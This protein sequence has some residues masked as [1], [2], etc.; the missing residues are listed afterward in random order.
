MPRKKGPRPRPFAERFWIRVHKTDGCWVWTGRKLGHGYGLFDNRDDRTRTT[1]A[2]RVS[3]QLVTG[4][5]LPS[6]LPLDHL[7]RNRCC[8]RPDHLEPVTTAENN[9]RAA[10]YRTH[11][12]RGH[13]YDEANTWRTRE[14]W[15]T[16]RTCHR[17][18]ERAR[19]HRE[20]ARSRGVIGDEHE[21]AEAA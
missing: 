14:G 12:R 5:I 7:C 13:A 1:L 6:D 9:R 3:Y 18:N 17:E 8:V 11:C 20:N 10:S 21:Q 15:R 19:R 16:C 2:H 4:K